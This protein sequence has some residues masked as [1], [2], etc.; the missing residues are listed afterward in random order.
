MKQLAADEIA[1]IEH[2]L[3]RAARI[4]LAMH[5]IAE[6]R[7]VI[8]GAPRMDGT[9]E[10]HQRLMNRA[11]DDLHHLADRR[12]GRPCLRLILK[13]Q[14]RRNLCLSRPL[15]GKTRRVM[16]RPGQCQRVQ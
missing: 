12:H 11:V 14:R 4:E 3:G 16:L 15:P 10:Q 2:A 13:C 9:F 6:G 5:K 7:E 8:T 1:I